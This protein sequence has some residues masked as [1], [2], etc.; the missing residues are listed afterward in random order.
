MVAPLFGDRDRLGCEYDLGHRWIDR[1]AVGC[2]D[3]FDCAVAFLR[4]ERSAVQELAGI[5]ERLEID[6]H[7]LCAELV[8]EMALEA[9]LMAA[10]V[11]GDRAVR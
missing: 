9:R 4:N 11:P 8:G 3:T 6:R 7:E 10:A 1:L 2:D 5:E